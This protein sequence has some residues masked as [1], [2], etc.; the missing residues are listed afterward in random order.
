MRR[1]DFIKTAALF[2]MS[3]PLLGKAYRIAP[4]HCII[5]GAGLAGLSAARILQKKGWE[6]TI[7]EA[8]NRIGGRVFSHR[9]AENPSLTCELGAEW[10]GASHERMIGLCRD[11]GLKLLDHRFDVSLL[12]NGV[13]RAPSAWGLS[14]EG[15][16]ALQEFYT[17]VGNYSEQQNRELD[18]IDWWT[19]LRELG[20]SDE[21]ILLRE[22]NDSTDFGESIRHVS[23]YA[24]AAEY[25]VSSP[26]DEMDFKVEGGNSRITDAL[27]DRIGL[28]V[29][30]RGERA[31]KVVQRNGMVTVST[32]DREYTGDACICT[33]PVASLRKIS[34]EP[35]LPQSQS[36]ALSQLQYARIVKASVLYAERFWGPD[37]FSILTDRTSHF[38]F[39]STKNQHGVEGILT[40]YTIG[41]KADVIANQQDSAK[42]DI[43]ANDIRPVHAS[44]PS[45]AKGIA[46]YAWQRDPSSEGAYALYRPGQ[47]YQVRP[48]LAV[49]HGKVIFAGEHLAD[50]QGFMEGAVTTGEEA[51]LELVR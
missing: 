49:P 14:A 51:A 30:R 29:I 41:D 25:S 38:Y 1:R 3:A 37:N 32:K 4:P 43:I 34:F 17:K 46:A 33:L 44:A 26:T 48:L 28:N 15:E 39:H 22:L 13:V 8:R 9:M 42:M 18:R 6:V 2:G 36:D 47:W 31:Q 16:R 23:A 40:S 24:A 12:R 27:V 35:P 21:D 20:L 10:I 50:A 11:L 45:L 19:K 5:L 7:L